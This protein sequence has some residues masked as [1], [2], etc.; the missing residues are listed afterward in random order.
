MANAPNFQ[1]QCAP[2]LGPPL[3]TAGDAKINHQLCRG[4]PRLN[5][6]SRRNTYCSLEL[7]TG[8]PVSESVTVFGGVITKSRKPLTLGIFQCPA[9]LHEQAGAALQAASGDILVRSGPIASGAFSAG[10]SKGVGHIAATFSASR[11]LRHLGPALRDFGYA[12]SRPSVQ[13]PMAWADVH[14]RRVW[15][16][17][18]V[19]KMIRS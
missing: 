14:R 16:V 6:R 17:G 8:A 12:F 19:S 9:R 2:A 3:L 10:S 5:Q 18:A 1:I 4:S 13:A 11:C 15:P 7:P